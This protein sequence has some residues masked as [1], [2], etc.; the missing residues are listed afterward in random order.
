LRLAIEIKDLCFSYEAREVF[1]HLDVTFEAGP[2]HLLLGP[3]GSGKTTLAFIMAGLLTPGS[4]SVTV[5]GIDPASRAFDRSK[6][7]LA[8]QF[9]EAQ[10]FESTVA[11]E[12]EY[13]LRNF[14]RTSG[15]VRALSEWALD[16]MGLGRDMLGLDPGSLSFGERRRVA[17]ASVIALKP[18]YLVLDEPLAGLD[19]Y[20]RRHLVEAVLRLKAEGVTALV[21]TH[22][23][24]LAAD[25]GDIVWVVRHRS[26]YGPAP[27]ERF[28]CDPGDAGEDLQPDHVAVMRMVASRMGCRPAIPVTVADV[29]E[30]IV[31][32]VR[33]QQGKI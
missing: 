12:I 27:V 15:E 3:T 31:R 17:L 24:D 18:D 21:L 14:A 28:V 4:G 23:A 19:W 25:V 33:P 32:L 9:P 6:V 13:G 10:I 11:R 2:V 16:C 5:D 22:E 1:S 20:G 30:A 7:Q 26:V 29:A 8:F